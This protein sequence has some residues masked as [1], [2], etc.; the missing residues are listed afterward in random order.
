M[1]ILVSPFVRQIVAITGLLLLTAC[2]AT[3]PVARP[4]VP[5]Q[6]QVLSWTAAI[7]ALH[8]L[9]NGQICTATLVQQDVVL[10]AAHCLSD[11]S[12]SSAPNR[13]AFL[14][15]EGAAPTFRALA[16]LRIRTIGAQVQQGQIDGAVAA[17]D[18]ALLQIEPAPL[19]LRPVAVSDLRWSEIEARLAAGD[20]FF[21]GGYGTPGMLA[22]TRHADCQPVDAAR[23]GQFLDDGLIASDCRVRPR[24]SGGPMVL[25]D[26]AGRPH[27]IAVISGI[28]RPFSDHPLGIGVEAKSFIKYL[29]ELNISDRS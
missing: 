14:P 16:V 21:S 27:L 13:F 25:I 23:L 19:G 5:P 8:D 22:L 1:P 28:G 26:I 11:S 9:G 12:T 6:P 10:T 2:A 18:W 24:D 29:N 15:N 4:P 20:R 7:G 17:G 3:P